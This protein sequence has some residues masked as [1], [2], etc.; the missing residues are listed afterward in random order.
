MEQTFTNSELLEDIEKN[1]IDQATPFEEH[2]SHFAMSYPRRNNQEVLVRKVIPT[3][4][5]SVNVTSS[6]SS[7][8]DLGGYSIDPT[9][10][11]SVIPRR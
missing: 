2:P 8:W 5:L 1:D 9:N 4:S 10:M 6:H 7:L 3:T 11:T